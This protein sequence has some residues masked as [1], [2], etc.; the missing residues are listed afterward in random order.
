M[1]AKKWRTSATTRART[2]PDHMH[3]NRDKHV[4]CFHCLLN[5][6][7]QLRAR[8]QRWRVIQECKIHG[9]H[10]R[11]AFSCSRHFSKRS[12][13][14]IKRPGTRLPTEQ[15]TPTTHSLSTLTLLSILL[16]LPIHPL[17]KPQWAPGPA[18]TRPLSVVSDSL[19]QSTASKSC[20]IPARLGITSF[21][22]RLRAF[23]EPTTISVC[24]HRSKCHRAVSVF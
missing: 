18:S 14:H 10:V 12:E 2:T 4:R 6:M 22:I 16:S 17:P 13:Q 8:F 23:E 1:L 7:L 11:K 20:I 9:C 3:T 5:G 15:V 21:I 24:V 19:S